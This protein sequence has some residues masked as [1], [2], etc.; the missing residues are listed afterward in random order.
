MLYLAQDCAFDFMIKNLEVAFGSDLML[1][2]F[3]SWPNL[4]FF[5]RLHG[6]HD[7]RANHGLFSF[8]FLHWVSHDALHYS[9]F[10]HQ[11]S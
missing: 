10:G 1:D 7:L 4:P 2:S 8:A 6:A 9:D 11:A 5:L 3:V